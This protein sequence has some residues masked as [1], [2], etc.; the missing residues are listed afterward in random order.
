MEKKFID[1][2]DMIAGEIY[3]GEYPIESSTTQTYIVRITKLPSESAEYIYISNYNKDSEWS[4]CSSNFYVGKTDIYKFREAFPE[5][6]VWY[7][8]CEKAG[9]IVDKPIVPLE[10]V[11]NNSYLIY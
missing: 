5:E 3:V 9:K 2:K 11:V 4:R 1:G 10:P 8:A 7:E 6:K